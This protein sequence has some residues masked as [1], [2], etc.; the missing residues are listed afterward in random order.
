[1]LPIPASLRNPLIIASAFL[2][3]TV[4]SKGQSPAPSREIYN[5]DFKWRVTIPEGF[6]LVPDS[7]WT[8]M[9]NK[10][11]AAIEMT[12]DKKVVNHAKTIFVFRSDQLHYF[13]SNYQPYDPAK[14]GS[15]PQTCKVVDDV[16]Y[17]T[18][19]TQLPNA[20]LDSSLTKEAIGGL[21]FY[22]F[23]LRIHINE[24]ATL[25][26]I[27]YS[28]LFGNKEFSV[29]IMYVDPA[30]GRSLLTAWKASSFGK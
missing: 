2:L 8:R 9:Q 16:L 23:N 29:N 25:H 26:M 22:V 18:F 27:M 11:A 10:G 3:Q 1:M 19:R 14:N 6:E 12:I 15:Y 24:R 17:E 13:E 21:E 28:H 20:R 7:V 5:K 4:I 30:K